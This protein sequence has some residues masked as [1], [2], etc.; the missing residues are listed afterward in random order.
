MNYI[1]KNRARAAAWRADNLERVRLYDRIRQPSPTRERQ[2]AQIESWFERNPESRGSVSYAQ[3]YELSE[4]ERKRAYFAVYRAEH[5]DH[6]REQVRA[7]ARKNREA[8]NARIRRWQREHPGYENEM[9]A[10]RLTRTP[11]WVNRRECRGFYEMAKRVSACLGI[12][13]HVDHYMPLQGRTVSGLHVP[14]NLRVLPAVL[15]MQKSN[16][17]EV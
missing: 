16:R 15:N 17:V 9:Q 3:A 1:E 12:P 7:N 5:K 6:L 2:L 8:I 11:K 13:H 4:V 10:S 14:W